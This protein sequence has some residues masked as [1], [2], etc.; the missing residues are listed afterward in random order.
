MATTRND[1]K[2]FIRTCSPDDLDELTQALNARRTVLNGEAQFKF[3]KGD[4]VK[5]DSGRR[6]VIRG[7]ITGWARGGKANIRSEY[8]TAWR[9]AGS[10]L[11][12]ATD[13]KAPPKAPALPGPGDAGGDEF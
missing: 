2:Q 4:A 7:T 10:L 11:R 13:P 6:G 12:D 9:V 5:F 3:K 1:V 8:G